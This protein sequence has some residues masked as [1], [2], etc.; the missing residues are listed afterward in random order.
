M[1]TRVVGYVRVSTEHQA[2]EGVSLDAQQARLCAYAVALNLCVVAIHVDS[3]ESG[4]TLDRPAL[5]AALGVLDAGQA[6]GLLV[7]ALDRLT[8]SVADGSALMK[9][10]FSESAGYSLHSV[11][12]SI[13]TRTAV[14]RFVLNMML[15]VHQLQRETAAER[16]R[17]ALAHVQ[18]LGGKVGA[19]GLGW[20]YAAEAGNDGRRIVETLDD[21]RDTIARMQALHAEGRSYRDIAAALTAEGRATKRGGRWFPATVRNVLL[22]A[23]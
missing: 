1:T 11:T 7:Y 19:A 10:Y 13:D 14:G 9:D 5:Q 21:E 16:T 8:R 6:D 22:R 2:N 17:D 15:S 20:R 18:S 23:S 3:G 4:G 12:D